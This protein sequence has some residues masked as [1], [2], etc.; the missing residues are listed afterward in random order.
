VSIFPIVLTYPQLSFHTKGVIPCYLTLESHNAAGLEVLA[1]PDCQRV[2]LRRQVTYFQPA[3]AGVA[4]NHEFNSKFLL[5]E[6]QRLPLDSSANPLEKLRVRGT[7]GYLRTVST[8]EA[9][10]SW[11]LPPHNVAQEDTLRRLEGEIWLPDTLQPSCET[12]YL[13][14]EVCVIIP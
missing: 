10:A 5:Q 7:D 12:D 9:I 13:R 14:I 8:E 4:I 3:G 6:E 2:R 11:W 1:N